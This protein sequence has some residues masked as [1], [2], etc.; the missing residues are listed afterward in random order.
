MPNP[1]LLAVG[2]ASLAEEEL[3]AADPERFFT[4]P[5]NGIPAVNVRLPAVGAGEC[6]ALITGARRSRRPARPGRRARPSS[7]S[8]TRGVV[9]R[10]RQHV[11]GAVTS[12]RN[13]RIPRFGRRRGTPATPPV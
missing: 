3:L 9:S 5:H 12:C 1:Q 10:A 13:Y 7:G 2:V 8:Q 11:A 6:A 4:E